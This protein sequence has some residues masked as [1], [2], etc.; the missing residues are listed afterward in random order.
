MDESGRGSYSRH[1]S[2]ETGEMS[3]LRLRRRPHAGYKEL[4]G[5]R[6]DRAA[7]SEAYVKTIARRC[8]MIYLPPN[9]ENDHARSVNAEITRAQ[10]RIQMARLRKS[11]RH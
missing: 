1:V 2:L 9:P 10:L 3:R 8:T 7:S 5:T 4:S 6:L 11:T